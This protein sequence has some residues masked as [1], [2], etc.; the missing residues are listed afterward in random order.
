[1]KAGQI[2]VTPDTTLVDAQVAQAKASVEA[3]HTNVDLA[4]ANLDELKQVQNTNSISIPSPSSR[5][6]TTRQ[7]E[8]ALAQSKAALKTQEY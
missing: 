8:G 1:V 5:H 7:A 6:S 2:L 3:A 4:Q